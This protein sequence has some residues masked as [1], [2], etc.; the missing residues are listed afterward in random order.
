MARPEGWQTQKNVF[1][2]ADDS[3]GGLT[4]GSTNKSWDLSDLSNKNVG[5]NIKYCGLT[6]K[7]GISLTIG[8]IQNGM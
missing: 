1:F 6:I 7:S 4:N 2:Q 5:S 8:D 3:D